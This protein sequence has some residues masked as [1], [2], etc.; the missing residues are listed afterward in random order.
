MW[1]NCAT[2]SNAATPDN[3]A[4]DA[5]KQ[6]DCNSISHRDGSCCTDGIADNAF[7]RTDSDTNSNCRSDRHTD[8]Y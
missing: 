5:Y 4:V 6:S 1:Q 3:G 8:P 7:A 2:F